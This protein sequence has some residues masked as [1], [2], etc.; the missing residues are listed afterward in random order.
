MKIDS[1]VHLVEPP[2]DETEVV[3]TCYDGQVVIPSNPRSMV[4]LEHLFN[5]MEKNKVEKAVVMGYQHCSNDFLRDVL[6]KHSDKLSCFAWVDDP[7]S[8]ES[9]KQLEEAVEKHGFKG[10]KMHPDIQGFC[11]SDPEIVPLIRKACELEV[12][13]LIH[14]VPGAM[15]KGFFNANLPEHILVLKKNVPDVD[16][17]IA[18]MGYPRHID[19][20]TI[21]LTPGIYIETSWGLTF[22]EMVHGTEFVSRFVHALGVDKVLYGSDWLGPHG[23]MENQLALIERLSLTR[24]EKSKILG[25]NISKLLNI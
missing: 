3:Y 9:A 6:K 10:L 7:K 23:E 16:V 22:I 2:N 25:G 24:E 13:V 17:I 20:L 19:L 14:S 15:S 8:E 21:S 4:S 5:S 12:P 11:A 18:H 1:H